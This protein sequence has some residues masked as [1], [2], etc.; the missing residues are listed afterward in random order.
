MKLNYEIFSLKIFIRVGLF[1]L[2][3]LFCRIRLPFGYAIFRKLCFWNLN[4]AKSLFSICSLWGSF[5]K[6]L[7]FFFFFFFFFFFNKEKLHFGTTTFHTNTTFHKFYKMRVT[8]LKNM[9][10]KSTF[11]FLFFLKMHTFKWLT[12]TKW[13]LGVNV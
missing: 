1:I 7:L 13:T 11:C 10:S 6:M 12:Q 3:F 8:Y 9:F 2:G 4:Q 5:S